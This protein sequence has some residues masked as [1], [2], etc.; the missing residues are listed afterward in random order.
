MEPNPYSAPQTPS[1]KPSKFPYILA[2]AFSCVVWAFFGGL[3]IAQYND[4]ALDYVPRAVMNRWGAAG[5]VGLFAVSL[6][7]L[8]RFVAGR[9]YPAA[10]RNM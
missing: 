7:Y 1:P 10:L 2:N 8:G 5:V 4:E 9:F 3:M 6:F